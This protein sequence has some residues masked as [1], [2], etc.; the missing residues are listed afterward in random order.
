VS[1]IASTIPPV[2]QI[3][4]VIADL[5]FPSEEGDRLPAAMTSGALPGFEH[6]ARFGERVIIEDGWRAWLARWL[7][8][9]DLAAV[10]PA[11][12]AAAALGRGADARD[13]QLAL[14]A[15]IE[16]PAGS[17][18]I[19]SHAAAPNDSASLDSTVWIATPVHL[20]AGLSTV[21]LDRRS[22]LRLSPADLDSFAS[23][24]QRV[25]LESGLRLEPMSSGEFLMYGLNI[26]RTLTT[27]PARAL[28]TDLGESLPK[29]SGAAVL[30]RLGAEL[31]M[32][33]H[34]HPVNELRR[35]R[36]DPPASTLWLWGGGSAALGPSGS[37]RTRAQPVS[38]AG[39]IKA[40][41]EVGSPAASR[42]QGSELAFGSDAYLAGLWHLQGGES[43]P[44][45]DQLTDVFGY[46]PVHRAAVVAEVAPMLHANSQWTVLEALAELDRRFVSPA[47]AL[48]RRGEVDGV[49]LIANDRQL[50][51]RRKDRLKLWR[52]PRSGIEGLR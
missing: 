49:V 37:H 17:T 9:D 27:E 25:F 3:V 29:G 45:P 4:I 35:K 31:E 14:K 22:L 51:V 40:T 23:D 7:G 2:R 16:A 52:R 41:A 28:V 13:A 5:Y 34:E 20:I 26:P 38:G 36:G 6:A 46:S 44:L 32:W 24:F 42:N 33:L 43:R 39:S 11:S 15:S 12:I 21:H 18:A 8:R 50:T 1:F 19:V 30:K 10:E 47:L 48:L